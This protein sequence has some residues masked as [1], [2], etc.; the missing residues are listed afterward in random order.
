MSFYKFARNTVLL[1]MRFAFKI[2]FHGHENMPDHKG[3]IL[4]AN[5]QTNIDPLFIGI[6][7]KKNVR[8]MAKEELFHNPILAKILQWVGTFP[9][10]RGKGD[11]SAI[12]TA[13]GVIKRGD[14]LGIFPE[15]T[16]S[17]DGTLKRAKSGAVVVASKTGGDIIPVGIKYGKKILWRR[18]IDVH[19]GKPITSKQLA[20]KEHNK[21]ELKAASKLLMESIAELLGVEFQGEQT[22]DNDS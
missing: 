19:Y 15:G 18:E 14:V 21:T 4:A 2:R 9:V 8:F 6:G 16:R 13:I 11:T 10:S 5:H 22:K 3:Y 7:C 1:V 12:E 17:H 20:L